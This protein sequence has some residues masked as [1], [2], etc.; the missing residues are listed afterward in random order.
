MW[1]DLIIRHI[2]YELNSLIIYNRIYTL[3]NVN[4]I[5]AI[6]LKKVTNFVSQS[7]V[8]FSS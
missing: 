2:S 3:A 8:K 1:D 6:Q 4:I 5:I 7:Q